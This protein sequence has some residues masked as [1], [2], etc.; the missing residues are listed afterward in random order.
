MMLGFFSRYIFTA[1]VYGSR[2]YSLKHFKI[3]AEKITQSARVKLVTTRSHGE[4]GANG[5]AARAYT[6]ILGT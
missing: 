6:L 3:E 2:F 4:H 1:H 5:R